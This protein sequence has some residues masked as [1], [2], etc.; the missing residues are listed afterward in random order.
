M[1]G[2]L[3]QEG[4]QEEFSEEKDLS[5]EGFKGQE[6]NSQLYS[7]RK[8]TDDKMSPEGWIGK[9]EEYLP[10]GQMVGDETSTWTES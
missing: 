6:V 8:E 3:P 2:P 4:V 1:G 10:E 9:S 5:P 7:G